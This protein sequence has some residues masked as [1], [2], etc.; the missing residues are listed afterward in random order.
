MSI[1]P[2][3]KNIKFIKLNKNKVFQIL[4][5]IENTLEYNHLKILI[6]LLNELAELENNQPEAYLDLEKITKSTGLTT[7][8]TNICLYR[9]EI[10]TIVSTY[11]TEIYIY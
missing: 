7:F 6:A 1:K 2:K 10:L 5:D 11:E 3:S 4:P 8:E 9:L